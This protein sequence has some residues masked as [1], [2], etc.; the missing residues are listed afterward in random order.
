MKH[1][2]LVW[3]VAWM[4]SYRGVTETDRPVGGGSFIRKKGFGGEVFNFEKYAGRYYGFG[5]PSGK[6]V[7]LQRLVP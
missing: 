3:R 1:R 7:N 6:T 5:Q 2:V 4:D